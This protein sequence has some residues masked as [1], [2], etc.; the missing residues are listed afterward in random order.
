MKLFLP[1]EAGGLTP[2][3]CAEKCRGAIARWTLAWLNGETFRCPYDTKW[4]SF[5]DAITAWKEALDHW[6]SKCK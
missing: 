4:H 1:D 6:E 3:E 5:A 2:K